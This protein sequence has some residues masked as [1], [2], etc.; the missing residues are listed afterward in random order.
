MTRRRI[1]D[2]DLDKHQVID[3][4]DTGI[5]NQMKTIRSRLDSKSEHIGA[6]N[7]SPIDIIPEDK[8]YIESKMQRQMPQDP[9]PEF[10]ESL[11]AEGA[12]VLESITYFPA[13]NTRLTKKSQT[14][15][16]IARERGYDFES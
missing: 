1:T 14:P 10:E 11:E 5:H 3:L 6:F 16:E 7:D 13:S 15:A 8:G 9:E 4:T 12:T 2:R